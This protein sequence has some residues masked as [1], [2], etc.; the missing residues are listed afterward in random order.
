MGGFHLGAE[1]A[2]ARAAEAGLIHPSTQVECVAAAELNMALRKTYVLNFPNTRTHY[3]F[4]ASTEDL[5]ALRPSLPENLQSELPIYNDQGEL[6]AVH[7]DLA[8]FLD[9]D[10]Q[11]LRK[12]DSKRNLL[13][14]HDLLCAGFP[15]QPFS[16]SG[17]QK[18]FEDTRGTVFHKIAT[19][20]KYCRPP[21]LFLENVGN[22]A[23]HDNGNTWTRV[24]AVLNDLGYDLTA[25]EPKALGNHAIGL[26]S[27]HQFGYP[28]HRERFFLVGQLRYEENSK[29]TSYLWDIIRKNPLSMRQPF[30]PPN[31]NHSGSLIH[32]KNTIQAAQSLKK[33]ISSSKKVRTGEEA[34]ARL[35]PNHMEAI[36]HWAKF[37]KK[38]AEY[39]EQVC[40]RG[41][42]EYKSLFVN[43]MPSFPIWGFELDPWNW[44]PYE[45]NPRNFLEHPD[46]LIA[47]R[48]QELISFQQEV[49]SVTHG[50]VDILAHPPQGKRAWISQLT[51]SENVDAWIASWPGYA[52][53]RAKWPKWKIRFLQQNRAFAFKLWSR[54]EPTWLR[55]WLD[56]LACVVLADGS[57]TARAPSHQKLEW[58]A[59]DAKLDIWPMVLQMRPSGIRVK[60]PTAVPA[61]VAMTTTQLPLVSTVLTGE[62]KEGESHYFRRIYTD[63]ALQFQGF[64][65]NWHLPTNHEQ[66]FT[67]LGNAVHAELVGDVIAAWWFNLDSVQSVEHKQKQLVLIYPLSKEH[68]LF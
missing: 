53:G 19:I 44:Y 20:L 65:G 57:Q 12:L 54:F 47:F 62:L 28:H 64:P 66:S 61:L 41:I 3:P 32:T 51:S 2:V 13:P 31:I 67:A 50:Q 14:D 30:R 8:V 45:E 18:G 49:A 21:L 25:T 6:E 38:L 43:E 10:E 40:G 39:D 15:C 11:G 5:D 68:E 33:I 17:F 58:N 29:Y 23:R 9:D 27:P 34:S 35:P 16:K 63:E 59:K 55:T 60:R 56:E 42:F 22:F 36:L 26:L 37:I 52:S 1:R 24:R 46:K 4:W 7:G 48:E